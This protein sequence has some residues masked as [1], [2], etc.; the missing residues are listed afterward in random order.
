[1]CWTG[2]PHTGQG[3]RYLPCT[4]TSSRNAVTFSGKESPADAHDDPSFSLRERWLHR[5]QQKRAHDPDPLKDLTCNA[6][7]EG[8]DVNGQVGKFGHGVE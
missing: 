1:M 7:F 4:A 6:G 5:A 3:F 2:E 8:I